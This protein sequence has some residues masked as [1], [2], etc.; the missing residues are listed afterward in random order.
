M[1][2]ILLETAA[3]SHQVFIANF[4]DSAG[5]HD[6]RSTHFADDNGYGRFI[7]KP[8]TGYLALCSENIKTSHN[9]ITDGSQHMK[10]V[11]IDVLDRYEY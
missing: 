9:A 5:I 2:A 4:G 8:P 10:C 11:N 7:T 6:Q 3:S 1:A